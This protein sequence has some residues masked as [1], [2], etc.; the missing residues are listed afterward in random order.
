MC[1]NVFE[2]KKDVMVHTSAPC[3]TCRR[4]IQRYKSILESVYNGEILRKAR[5]CDLF[6]LKSEIYLSIRYLWL[7]YRIIFL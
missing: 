3:C 4:P 6:C 1:R 7:S 5:I 2:N